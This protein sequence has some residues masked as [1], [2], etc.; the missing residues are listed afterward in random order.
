MINV[1]LRNGVKTRTLDN[2]GLRQTKSEGK[3]YE[4]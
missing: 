2:S 1:P 3:T 4:I